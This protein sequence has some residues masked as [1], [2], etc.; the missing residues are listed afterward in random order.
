MLLLWVL[1]PPHPAPMA[2]SA[3]IVMKRIL[4]MLSLMN[5]LG[6]NIRGH[7]FWKIGASRKPAHVPPQFDDQVRLVNDQW[8]VSAG[9]SLRLD[10]PLEFREVRTEK[11]L[12]VRQRRRLPGNRKYLSGGFELA[13][14]GASGGSKLMN[15]ITGCLRYSPRGG[16][17]RL[18]LLN[19][20]SV[21]AKRGKGLRCEAHEECGPNEK[22]DTSCADCPRLNLQG[23]F[24]G[25][26]TEWLEL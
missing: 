23:T 20:S 8:G 15:G 2:S 3:N 14:D 13:Y 1:P 4:R 10:G 7:I 21:S 6:V 26:T 16:D 5:I 22:L 19:R 17:M 25:T 9:P 12:Q 24:R 18:I 11:L